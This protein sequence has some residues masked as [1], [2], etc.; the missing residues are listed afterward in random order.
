MERRSPW[1]IAAL[2]EMFWGLVSAIILFFQLLIDPAAQNKIKPAKRGGGGSGGYGG[3]GG[4]RGRG[5]IVGM[6][7]VKGGPT[8]PPCGGGG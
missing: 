6:D 1:S 7:D 4:P 5:R 3:S 8:D 2:L